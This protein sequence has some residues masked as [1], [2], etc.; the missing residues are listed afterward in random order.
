MSDP[1]FIVAVVAS[2]ILGAMGGYMAENVSW[3]HDCELIGAH[4]TNGEVYECKKKPK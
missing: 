1:P 3:R 4:R 2:L